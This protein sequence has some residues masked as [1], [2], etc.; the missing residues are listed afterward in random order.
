M[1]KYFLLP[2]FFCFF[3]LVV[4]AQDQAAILKV[5]QNQTIAW[6]NY[7]LDGFMYGYW[8]SDSLLFVSS[9]E[10]SYGWKTTLEHYKKRYPDKAAMGSLT[11]TILKV[12]LL[13]P[14]NAFILGGW[15]LLRKDDR[16]HGY[17]TLWFKK[18]DNEWKIVVDHTS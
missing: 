1:I 8:H 9:G 5:L 18:I 10:P 17:F 12:E 14:T 13:D 11:F 15:S 2:I 3:S 6:N 7:D 16:P 4:L